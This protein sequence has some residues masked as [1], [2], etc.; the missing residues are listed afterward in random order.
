[1]GISTTTIAQR[2]LA[3]SIALA[4]LAYPL[5]IYFS[6]NRHGPTLLAAGL[7][8][9]CAL[10]FI[11][12]K[13]YRHRNQQLL[14]VCISIFCALVIAANSHQLLRYYPSLMNLGMATLFL[15]SLRTQT[16]LI[17]RM[18]SA[19]GQRPPPEAKHYIRN[20]TALWGL[21][22]L[23]NTG[24]SAYTACCTRLSF[25]SFYNGFAAYALIGLIIVGEWLYRSVYKKQHS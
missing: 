23:L 3:A 5:I 21:L 14:L 8:L 12:L 11:A 18:A 7:W 24:I 9:L 2:V 10:R 1:M 4:V 13:H 25:W 6:I 20:L 19:M 16:P 22:L 17:A 15:Y